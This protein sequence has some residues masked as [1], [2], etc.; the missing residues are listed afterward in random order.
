MLKNRV[1]YILL[2]FF[3]AI[4]YV[5]L[6]GYYML[7]VLLALVLLPLCS[8]LFLFLTRR[9]VSLTA[10]T[11]LILDGAPEIVYTLENKSPLPAAAVAWELTLE[12]NLNGGKTGQSL[13]GFVRGKGREEARLSLVNARTGKLI[14]ATKKARITDFFGL[15]AFPIPLPAP[16][17]VYIYPEFFDIAQAGP[18]RLE[19]DGD[20]VNYSQ[21]RLGPD[22]NE[23][24]ALH[25][26]AEGD[27]LRKVHWKLSSKTDV[28][29]V[30]DF[31]L[32]LNSQ[33]TLLLELT[34]PNRSGDGEELSLCLDIFASLSAALAQRGTVHNIAWYDREYEA[35]HMEQI[36]ELAELQIALPAL[37]EAKAYDAE[38]HALQ[39]YMQKA[40]DS[41]SG[42]MLYYITAR[43]DNALIREAAN[44]QP[45]RTIVV[46]NENLSDPGLP[47][48]ADTV[49]FGPDMRPELAI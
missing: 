7:L 14:A 47:E 15:F 45:L 9:K 6:D 13:R 43:P 20:C 5:F 4:L 44:I 24:F 39:C 41:A 25:E 38:P 22:V 16:L 37:L 31:G 3:A 10:Q 28:L 11:P 12:D 21:S 34:P 8:F 33:I 18:N 26:Y 23:V 49:R 32:P 48:E 42:V 2:L 30:R 46:G 36:T 40:A 19:S 27:D 1:Q 29:M 35:F 17:N